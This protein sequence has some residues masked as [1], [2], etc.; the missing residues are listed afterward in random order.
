MPREAAAMVNVVLLNG[1]NVRLVSP[2][3]FKRS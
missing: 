1:V 2:D 3:D